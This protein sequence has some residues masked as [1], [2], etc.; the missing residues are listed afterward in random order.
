M[1]MPRPCL[2]PPVDLHAD[3]PPLPLCPPL[4]PHADA[5]AL[6][7][8][9]PQVGEAEKELGGANATNPFA[10]LVDEAEGLDKIEDLQV[11][12][13]WRTECICA[14]LGHG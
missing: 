8:L 14:L 2:S 6:S 4:H 5:P 10:Q 7:A 12:R 13:G 1:L 9:P 3:V 11:G